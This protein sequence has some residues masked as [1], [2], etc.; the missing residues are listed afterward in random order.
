G[1]VLNSIEMLPGVQAGIDGTPGYFVRGGNTGQNLILLDDATLYN[2]SHIFG[3]VSTFNP[4]NI[5]SATLL[6]GG[7]PANYGD[8]VSS[9]LDVVSKDGSNH[10][11]GGVVQMGSVTSGA[12]L[13]GP[14]EPGRSSFLV[15]GRRSTT[16]VLLEPLLKNNY[17][18]NYY[19]YDVNAKLNF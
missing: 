17:F 14:L 16:D 18:R 6:K 11:L 10:Q 1:D 12:T 19:F 4:P 13:Y 9:V 3:L 7:F 2:P 8:H 5:K 15:S